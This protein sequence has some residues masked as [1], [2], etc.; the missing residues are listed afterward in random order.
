MNN[1]FTGLK[2]F[3]AQL[4]IAVDQ[5]LNVLLFG[6]ADET[7]SARS[8]R[9]KAKGRIFGSFMLPIIDALFAWQKQPNDRGHCYNA[10]LKEK[11]KRGLPPEYRDAV[12]FP[13]IVKE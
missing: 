4:F 3:G 11:E 9:A 8:Y 12:V 1:F 6:F 2:F 13:E 10:Y 5:L 7:L